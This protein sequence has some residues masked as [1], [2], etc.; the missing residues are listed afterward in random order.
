MITR[1]ASQLH[2]AE[3]EGLAMLQNPLRLASEMAVAGKENM[4]S[5]LSRIPTIA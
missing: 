1:C 5:I 3:P 2:L 4:L